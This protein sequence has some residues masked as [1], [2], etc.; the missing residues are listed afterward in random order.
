MP[1]AVTPEGGLVFWGKPSRP[2]TLFILVKVYI[3]TA[4]WGVACVNNKKNLEILPKSRS[5]VAIGCSKRW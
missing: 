1:P 4:N 2:L 5:D 3:R